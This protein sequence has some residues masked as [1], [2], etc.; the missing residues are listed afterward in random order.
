MT[1]ISQSSA[2]PHAPEWCC[3]TGFCCSVSIGT[4]SHPLCLSQAATV[5]HCPSCTIL[6]VADSSFLVRLRE[7]PPGLDRV[8]PHPPPSRPAVEGTLIDMSLPYLL[9]CLS[10]ASVLLR[11]AILKS[12]TA[13]P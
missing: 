13:G 3:Y 5:L 7:F 12:L 4:S 10:H 1:D 9:L 2:S 11:A 8:T 6:L